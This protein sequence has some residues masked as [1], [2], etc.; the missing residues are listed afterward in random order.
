M[1]T[2]MRMIAVLFL[3][4][5]AMQAADVTGKWEGEAGGPNGSFPLKFTFKQ[6]GAKLTGTMEGPQ[7]DSM[8][9]SDGKVDG[10][11]IAFTVK[12][13][14]GGGGMKIGH[15][16]TVKGDEMKLAVKFEGGGPGGEG[17]GPIVLKRV[18]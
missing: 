14:R 2:G 18:K 6:D 8:E 7:G 16:G 4:A 5:A 10:E 1:N 3:A 17:P 11:K 13:D 9:I 12:F 15:Q